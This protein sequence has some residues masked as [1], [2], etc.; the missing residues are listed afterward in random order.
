MRVSLSKR[1]GLRRQPGWAL[2]KDPHVQDP[3]VRMALGPGHL[4]LHRAGT[5]M[6][7]LRGW[8]PQPRH[9]RDAETMA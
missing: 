8:E 4:C 3:A 7:L 9:D 1:E 6:E 5:E 2:G